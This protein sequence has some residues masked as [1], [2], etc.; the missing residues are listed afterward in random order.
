MEQ[1]FPM[2]TLG[3]GNGG[4]GGKEAQQRRLIWNAMATDRSQ[5]K[6]FGSCVCV[7]YCVLVFTAER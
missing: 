4:G 3:H 6:C 1:I 5:L 7:G 2:C